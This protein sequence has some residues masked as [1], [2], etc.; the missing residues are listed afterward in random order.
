[1]AGVEGKLGCVAKE[2][3]LDIPLRGIVGVGED[4]DAAAVEGVVA[5]FPAFLPRVVGF[6][7]FQ[8]RPDEQIVVD[9]DGGN[10]TGGCAVELKQGVPELA[11]PDAERIVGSLI[12][13]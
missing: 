1:M 2:I 5:Q 8:L 10:F 6:V 4:I 7:G 9:G 11:I 13:V 3:V 12:A